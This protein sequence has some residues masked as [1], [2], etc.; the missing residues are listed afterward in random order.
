M[1]YILIIDVKVSSMMRSD[2][3][4][5]D[6]RWHLVSAADDVIT[7]MTVIFDKWL[8][9]RL[10]VLLIQRRTN[11]WDSVRRQFCC[12]LRSFKLH[13]GLYA[14]LRVRY[15]LYGRSLL[16]VSLR[17]FEA[18]WMSTSTMLQISASI[19]QGSAIGPVSYDI[20]IHLICP[21]LHQVT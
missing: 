9:I 17:K 1:L 14:T 3:R 15:F 5:Y 10:Y 21:L 19:I 13:L 11:L 18:W 12:F 6:D 16:F 4:G 7:V 20:N 2:T 8:I